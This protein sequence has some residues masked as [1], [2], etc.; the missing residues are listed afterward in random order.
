MSTQT[1]ITFE[2]MGN[3]ICLLEEAGRPLL[4]T[5]PW[6]FGTVYFGSW[7]LDHPLTEQQKERILHSKYL[8][9]SH[10]HPDHLHPD[11]IELFPR[12]ITILLGTH[13]SNDVADFF[14]TKGFTHIIPCKNRQ[15]V[16]LSD[17]V[18]IFCVSNI[19]QDSILVIEAGDAII[20]NQNDSPLFG[21]GRFFTRLIKGYSN[22]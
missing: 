12:D 2:T 6:L 11:S 18:R 7:A 9:I 16:R 8:W 17:H 14:R 3:A 4:V 5:D 1:A 20:I 22:S 21:M 15:W 10:G 13:Y 19:N